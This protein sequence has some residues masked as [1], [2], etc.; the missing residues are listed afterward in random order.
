MSLSSSLGSPRSALGLSCPTWL[1][2]PECLRLG[3][4]YLSL[5]S[6]GSLTLSFCKAAPLPR[7][8]QLRMWAGIS[9]AKGWE[10]RRPPDPPREPRLTPGPSWEPSSHVSCRALTH[11][12]LIRLLSGRGSGGRGLPR[13]PAITP[14]PGH[15]HG[16]C[17]TR[18]GR[19][20]PE[21]TACPAWCVHGSEQAADPGRV[22][23]GK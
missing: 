8:P 7:F 3:N 5:L 23:L 17:P 20:G 18:R 2:P 15:S 1:H 21:A 12:D 11:K 4:P 22:A 16:R 9:P 13:R 14:E 6:L 19:A 10:T